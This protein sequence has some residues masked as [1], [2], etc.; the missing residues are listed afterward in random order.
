MIIPE[1]AIFIL[2]GAAGTLKVPKEVGFA[3]KFRSVEGHDVPVRLLDNMDFC[4]L[5]GAVELKFGKSIGEAVGLVADC[6]KTICCNSAS[7]TE[8]TG[9]KFHRN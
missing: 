2:S 9:K 1:E 4:N 3:F 6:P 5:A 7:G 8:N